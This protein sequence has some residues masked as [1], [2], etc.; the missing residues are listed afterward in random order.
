V[1]LTLTGNESVRATTLAGS[2]SS[3]F[4]GTEAP[5]T[6]A[7]AVHNLKAHDW[8]QVWISLAGFAVLLVSATAGTVAVGWRQRAA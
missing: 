2:P 8:L 7:A 1:T 6:P 5:P 3:L 4:F